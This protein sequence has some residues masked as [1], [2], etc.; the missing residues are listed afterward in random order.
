MPLET[1]AEETIERAEILHLTHPLPIW[2]VDDNHPTGTPREVEVEDV[3]ALHLHPLLHPGRLQVAAGRA[4]RPIVAVAADNRGGRIAVAM[5]GSPRELLEGH[6]VVGRPP[7][8]GEGA[9]Q[10]RRR[11]GGDQRSLH[12]EGPGPAHRIQQRLRAVVIG[13]QE[14]AGR[15]GFGE[16]SGAASRPVPAVR[17]GLP[18]RVEAQ[19]ARA[20]LH[21]AQVQSHIGPLAVHI[22]S[23]AA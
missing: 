18:A 3:T 5:A 22:R 21:Q 10:T 11:A 15:Q 4:H 16:R 20:S 12:D 6:L 14:D 13:Q 7:L 19:G 17:E 1:V 9:V 2:R 23:A 8:E